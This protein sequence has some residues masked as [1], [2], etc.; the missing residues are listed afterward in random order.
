MVF[1]AAT[2]ATV[3]VVVS[4]QP[5]P[6]DQ[7]TAPN[8]AAPVSAPQEAPAD[9]AVD[10]RVADASADGSTAPSNDTRTVLVFV[11]AAVPEGDLL[12]LAVPE[13]AEVVRVDGASD[14]IRQIASLLEGRSG[15]DAIHIVSHGGQATLTLGTSLLDAT[16]IN[17]IYR[18]DLE[19]IGRAMTADGDILV[20]GCDFA[21]GL[22]GRHAA[23]LLG[24]VTGADVSASIDITGAAELG[25]DWTLE[26]TAGEVEAQVAFAAENLGNWLHT[27]AAPVVD[28]DANNSSGATGS[29]FNRTFTENGGAVTIADVDATIVD[30]DSVNLTGMTVS[31]SANPDGAAESLSANTTGTSIT[32]NYNS[33]TGVLSL[34]GTDTTANYQK[35][36]RTIAYN[37]TSDTPTT[38]ARSIHVTAT[39]GSAT[40]AVATTNLTVVAVNDPPYVKEAYGSID[41]VAGE[42]ISIP[43]HTQFADP[44]GQALSFVVSGLPAGLTY[45]STTG[46]ITGTLPADAATSGPYI[47]TI[48]ASDGNGGSYAEIFTVE[49]HARPIGPG[50]TSWTVGGNTATTTLANGIGVTTTFSANSGAAFSNLVNDTL[51]SI[52][53]FGDDADM[54]RASLSA[55]F[56]WD[57]TP[58]PGAEAASIDA[59][60]GTITITFSQAVTNPILYIDKLGGH[61]DFIASSAVLTLQSAG[62]TL[63]EIGG[64]KH[65]IVNEAAGTIQRTVGAAL[66]GT[67]VAESSLD[68]FE[69]TA[70]GA[71]RLLGTFSTVTFQI[72]AAT[73]SVEGA[74][75]DTIELAVRVDAPPVADNEVASVGEDRTLFVD[76]ANGVLAGDTDADGNSLAVSQFTVAG[77]TGS[78]A[79][80]STAT[81]AGV[82]ALTINGNG[83]YLFVPVA[84]F[85]GAVP[86]AT[87][88]VTDGELSSSATLTLTVNSS[89]DRP[90]VDLDG[91][92]ATTA[93]GGVG[94]LYNSPPDT[95]GGS[96]SGIYV[97]SAAAETL[98]AGLSRAASGTTVLV[99]GANTATY[100]SALGANDYLQFGFTTSSSASADT[101]INYLTVA[102]WGDSAAYKIAVEISS[103][104]FATRST[105]VRDL[106]AVAAGGA[107]YE[108]TFLDLPDF[109]LAASTTYAI[110]VYFYE[111]GATTIRFDDLQFGFDQ[112][113]RSHATTYTENAAPVS[114]ANTGTFIADPDNANMASATVTLTNPQ[115]GDRLV[116]N[117]SAAASGTL[118]SGINWTRTD[119]SV[120]LSGS[121]T[122][123]QYAAALEL[124]QF[125][126]TSNLP[127][128]A[129]RDVT[130]VVSDGAL[131][132]NT[133]YTSISVDRA[134]DPVADAFSGNEDAAISGNV[135]TNDTDTGDGPASPPLSIVTGPANGTLSS[136]NTTTGAFTYTPNANFNGTDSFVYRYTDG[137]GDS[138]TATVTLTVSP[139]NDAPVAA[140]DVF[141]TAEDTAVTFDVRANDADVDGNALT[142]T[143]IN[144]TAIA[145]GGSVAVTGGSVTLN[146]GGTLTFTPSANYT[147]APSFTYTVSD[148]SGAASDG[149]VT[150]DVTPVPEFVDTNSEGGPAEL[151]EFKVLARRSGEE[152]LGIVRGPLTGA[153]RVVEDLRSTTDFGLSGVILKAVNGVANL[154]SIAGPVTYST[155]DPTDRLDWSQ[156][157]GGNHGISHGAGLQ[158]IS[159]Q[160]SASLVLSGWPSGGD[161]R[162]AASVVETNLKDG[163]LIVDLSRKVG[164]LAAP[165]GEVRFMQSD[166]N[167]LPAWLERAG[168]T[169]LI[170]KVP[171]NVD[172]VSVRAV[173]VERDGSQVQHYFEI[174]LRTGQIS[175][176]PQTI[177]MA[178][179]SMFD[180]GTMPFGVLRP[181]EVEALGRQLGSDF[182]SP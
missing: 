122:K 149:I 43:V 35:V 72:A 104:N 144:G 117:G 12:A 61:G 42:P 26:Y 20:Y 169:G 85:A 108:T 87:Y 48:T 11:D 22:D 177:E 111:A 80:G 97:S 1:D 159:D 145:V 178:P 167:A 163:T 34:S 119:T 136:F 58:G 162:G 27:L 84:D 134:P 143:Q 126:S 19:V 153:V 46:F 156:D 77:V 107:S 89:N 123:A 66:N 96:T 128:T 16:S 127:S 28:L 94:W 121:F 81:I 165:H 146:A 38:S 139:V 79:A 92:V 141:T 78:F 115:S 138:A 86:V 124:V 161:G 130:T 95:L 91:S 56:A 8:D 100:A 93:V 147:G 148:G 13:G 75:G 118:A 31:L 62:I 150:G 74:G 90:V 105:L 7:A 155:S 63:Q 132:S 152:E 182:P 173:V 140:G 4:D 64:T 160:R 23:D 18:A 180:F 176:L 30:I 99:T 40:S 179:R 102:D 171:P 172:S 57:T 33:S 24:Q 52:P 10:T 168:P 36:L 55:G 25:G 37:N 174:D 103:D 129:T 98:G 6:A 44:E 32:A 125:E 49:G 14:G 110:R 116:V 76:S 17:G 5:P 112:N 3:E 69:G 158:A 73:G 83:S 151:D 50:S 157:L 60:T 70:A 88:T 166:G 164:G 45:N 114:V 67:S 41:G 142:V 53:A 181:E 39:D 47:V 59:S 2:S 135:A 154:D 71:V 101:I 54:G 120:V 133:A 68:P 29:N 137:D 170:G 15:I 51:N 21:S 131:N 113:S 9:P 175:E 109:N 65:F 106:Q 82:G